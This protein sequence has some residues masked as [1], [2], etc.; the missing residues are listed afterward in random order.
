MFSRPSKEEKP[1]FLFFK[2]ATR[3]GRAPAVSW[4][5]GSLCWAVGSGARVAQAACGSVSPWYRGTL[6]C[7][8]GSV[9]ASSPGPPSARCAVP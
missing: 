2:G 1:L 6:L 8:P 5:Q 7:K 9:T 4:P 3:G